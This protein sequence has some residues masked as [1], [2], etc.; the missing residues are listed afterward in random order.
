[1]DIE[2]LFYGEMTQAHEHGIHAYQD[3]SRALSAESHGG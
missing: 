2:S 3:V 1:M